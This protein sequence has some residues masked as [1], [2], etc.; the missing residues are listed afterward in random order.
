MPDATLS[1]CLPE[2]SHCPVVVTYPTP[3]QELHLSPS[4]P[5]WERML[6]VQFPLVTMYWAHTYHTGLSPGDLMENEPD[7]VSDLTGAYRLIGETCSQRKGNQD[8][9]N[10]G[11]GITERLSKSQEGIPPLQGQ[12]NTMNRGLEARGSKLKSWAMSLTWLA[13]W[14]WASHLTS[15]SLF[16]SS[17]KWENIPCL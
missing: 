14:P 7:V 9:A 12:T 6:D 5:T 2:G 16:S 17:I 3:F 15:L 1:R 8:L 11:R 10:R 4:A 13:M